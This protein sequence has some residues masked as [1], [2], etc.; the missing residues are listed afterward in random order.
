MLVVG[1]TGGIGS[2]KSAVSDAFARLGVPVIDTDVLA[3]ELVEPGQPAL[4]EI[5]ATFGAD[6]LG[7]D[8]R[9]D[10][11]R[12]RERVFADD[13]ARRRLEAILHP[14]I[15]QAVQ[16]RLVRLVQL[17][18]PYCLLVIPLLVE[19]GMTDLVQRV[20]VVDVPEE[21]QVARVMQRDRVSAEQ[22]RAVLAAQAE[23]AQRLA[24]ADDVLDNSGS[25]AAL[26]DAV[27]RLHQRY[28]Q[29]AARSSTDP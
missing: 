19:S 23:R 12:L 18:T 8:G 11:R 20:L 10:R 7:A 9:L 25:R 22:A 16:Q 4:G 14:R 3:R 28:L 13:Q 1:L 2:G 5:A 21:L 27:R 26:E 24:A 15:R 17:Q 6:C 29:L